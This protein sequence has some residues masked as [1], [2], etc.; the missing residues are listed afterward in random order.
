MGDNT[1]YHYFYCVW[2]FIFISLRLICRLILGVIHCLVFAYNLVL[3]MGIGCCVFGSFAA[4]GGT[5]CVSFW[6]WMRMS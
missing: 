6:V 2:I 5:C 3:L 4:L 1:F